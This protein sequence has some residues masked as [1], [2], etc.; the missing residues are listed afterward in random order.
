VLF[1]R[2]ISSYHRKLLEFYN[3]SCNG[4]RFI[5]NPV[6][7]RV[8]DLFGQDDPS[9]RGVHDRKFLVPGL[10]QPVRFFSFNFFFSQDPTRIDLIDP[11]P[12]LPKQNIAQISGHRHHSSLAHAVCQKIGLAAPRVDRTDIENSTIGSCESVQSFS[13]Q[14]K[15]GKCVNL[16]HF[17]ENRFV[18]GC[19]IGGSDVSCIIYDDIQLS[20]VFQGFMNNPAGT[21]CVSQVIEYQESVFTPQAI[22]Y[23]PTL[24]G[25]PTVDDYPGT[26]AY[27]FPGNRLPDSCGTSCN[28]YYFIFKSHS[29][30]YCLSTLLTTSP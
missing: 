20:V 16:E 27:T 24:R 9:G 12:V 13:D 4:T 23:F 10:R 14:Q 3:L 21:V 19:D 8:S 11:D 22:H 26:F 5:G 15:R 30:H 18:G 28:Q 1:F 25:F 17:I 29:G 7:D 2:K 6:Y